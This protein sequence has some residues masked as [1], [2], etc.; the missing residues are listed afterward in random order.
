MQKRAADPGL[1]RDGDIK[2]LVYT[3]GKWV[4]AAT[5]VEP[6]GAA[7]FADLWWFYG[8]L[9][10][11]ARIG[12]VLAAGAVLTVPAPWTAAG[13]ILLSTLLDWVDG[14]VARKYGHCTI[15]GSGADW[16]G[17]VLGQVVTLV[18]WAQLDIRVLPFLLAFTGVELALSIFDFA[19]TA[20]GLYPTFEGKLAKRYNWFYAIVDWSQPNGTDSHFGTFLWLAY[21]VFCLVSC[22]KLAQPLG[23][24]WLETAQWVLVVPALLYMWCE[25]AYLGFILRNW[26]EPSRTP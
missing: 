24:W 3:K 2:T 20:T 10:D 12:L 5:F 26:R 23:G 4:K 1:P 18:W 21:P 11:Y 19:T 16:L 14:P 22:L 13:L 7:K 15:F 6:P 9:I 8:N 17:D 25:T